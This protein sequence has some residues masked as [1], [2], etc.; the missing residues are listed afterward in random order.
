MA[1]SP[2]RNEQV[3]EGQQDLLDFHP[4]GVATF[5]ERKEFRPAKHDIY[6][7]CNNDP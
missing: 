7:L 5:G 4:E 6:P 3:L 1:N 2:N